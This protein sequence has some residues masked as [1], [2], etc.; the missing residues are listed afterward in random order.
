MFCILEGIFLPH[1]L[2]PGKE[3]HT[4]A[5]VA[6]AADKSVFYSQAHM[7]LRH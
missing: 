7:M 4:A 2:P 6:A 3:L 1:F 5:A